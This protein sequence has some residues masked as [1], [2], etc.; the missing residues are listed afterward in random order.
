[1][2]A[3][4][5]PIFKRGVVGAGP[6][7]LKNIKLNGDFVESV[8]LTKVTNQYDVKMYHFYSSQE[9]LKTAFLSRRN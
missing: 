4:S 2:A 6:Y 9:A 3:V 8:T 7:V 5:K 1:L